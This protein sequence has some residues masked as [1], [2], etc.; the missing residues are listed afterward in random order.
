MDFISI[1][2]FIVMMQTGV[3]YL[4]LA[5]I[6]AIEFDERGI[7]SH[8]YGYIIGIYSLSSV[9]S[10]FSVSCLINKYGRRCVLYS[11]LLFMSMSVMAIGLLSH[12]QDNTLM[13]I[14]ALFLRTIEGWFKNFITVTSY[15]II[16]ILHPN[17]KIK[18]IGLLETISMFG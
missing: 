9:L 14:V 10:S 4:I 1:L 16:V 8:Y 15:S 17:E 7:E 18:Y 5:S 12:I 3:G 13:I 2:I 11:G 6:L